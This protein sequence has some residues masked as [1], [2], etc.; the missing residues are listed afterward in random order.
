M[1]HI[2]LENNV[3]LYYEDK[4]N[5]TPILFI[6][7]VWMSSRFFQKQMPYFSEKYRSISVDLRG[8]GQSSHVETGHTISTYAHDLHAF[9]EALSLK[10][11]ILVG[12]SM[13]AFVVW[14][15]I[16]QF[17][18]QNLKASVIVD[19]LASDY[20]WPDFPIGA[21]DFPTLIHFMREV[22]TNQVEF[23]KGFIPL[24]FKDPLSEDD[25]A[26]M[27][28]E[29]TKVP[30]SIASAILFDQSAVDYREDLNK[31]TKPTLLCFGR[32]EKLIPVAAGEHLHK[33]INNSQFVIFENSCHCPFLEETDHFN[34]VVDSFIQSL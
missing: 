8:H 17:G 9:I 19:E 7:G 30:A 34:K 2:T 4:G 6:H 23:L 1:P 33:H 20:K 24:M 32:E 3:N 25:S 11:V 18:E 31:I 22:Q 15:Y 14:E 10:N 27:L 28:E 29:V 16:K 13:G 26:W 21:F 12:W 5:G